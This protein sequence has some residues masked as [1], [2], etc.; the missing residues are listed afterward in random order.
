M[1]PEMAARP[2]LTCELPKWRNAILDRR[3]LLGRFSA[4]Q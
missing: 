3:G 2:H 4:F 1:H